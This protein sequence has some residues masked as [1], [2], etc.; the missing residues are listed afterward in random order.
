MLRK[1]QRT[2]LQRTPEARWGWCFFDFYGFRWIFLA[3][4]GA[5]N[6]AQVAL[7]QAQAALDHAQQAAP[8]PPN[9]AALQQASDDAQAVYDQRQAGY[10]A[11]KDALEAA[12]VSI[13]EEGGIA[14]QAAALPGLGVNHAGR[15]VPTFSAL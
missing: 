14:L 5:L 7:D 8:A 11:A 2:G 9:L 12:G 4:E 6:Q 13:P 1:P 15:V 10:N 3:A